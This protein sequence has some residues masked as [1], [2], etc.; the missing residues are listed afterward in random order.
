[1][2][3]PLDYVFA[4]GFMALNFRLFARWRVEGRENVPP[5]GPLIVVANHTHYL[6]PPLVNASVSRRVL[7][8]AKSEL[9]T[10]THGWRRWCL[11]HY[12]LIPIERR[13]VDRTA[14]R[15][16]LDHLS[17]GG[18]IG[19]FP[20]G[21]RSRSGQLQRAQAGAALLAL[22]SGAPV[23]PVGIVGLAGLRL[24]PSVVLRRPPVTVRI[25]PAFTLPFPAT[26]DRAI[27]REA[28]DYMLGRVAALLL[29]GMRGAYAEAG[30]GR[31]DEGD[32]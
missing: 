32:A 25:G 19:L 12:G 11:V 30:S 21:T 1:M 2:R 24:G 9:M 20:E 31:G 29:E 13:R 28:S 26:T 5:R 3:D 7:Y 22:S 6:D 16:A 17:A 4:N 14:L 8:L 15:R 23:L 18:V 10:E 27:L